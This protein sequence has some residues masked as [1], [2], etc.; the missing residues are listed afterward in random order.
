MTTY[1]YMYMDFFAQAS[2]HTAGSFAR[3]KFRHLLSL[4]KSFFLQ[5]F[6]DCTIEAGAT[7][8]ASVKMKCFAK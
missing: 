4:V 7:F 3:R 5:F 1:M 8:T 2:Y 6:Y